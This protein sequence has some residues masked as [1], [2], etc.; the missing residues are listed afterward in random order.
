M[1]PS[2]CWYAERHSKCLEACSAAPDMAEGMNAPVCTHRRACLRHVQRVCIVSPPTSDGI[3]VASIIGLSHQL[4]CFRA[5]VS[6]Q[7]HPYYTGIIPGFAPG[8]SGPFQVFLFVSSDVAAGSLH[9]PFFVVSPISCINHFVVY[10]LVST[11]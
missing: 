1:W 8:F 4:F 3:S 5:L 11:P 10:L 6:P 9:C 7:M 2:D